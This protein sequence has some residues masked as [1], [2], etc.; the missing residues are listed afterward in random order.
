M[1]DLHNAAHSMQA[2]A[3]ERGAAEGAARLR[4]AVPEEHAHLAVQL[5]LAAQALPGLLLRQRRAGLVA[6]RLRTR[7]GLQRRAAGHAAAA[8]PTHTWRHDATGARAVVGRRGVPWRRRG[9]QRRG[10]REQPTR[11]SR[12]GL[13]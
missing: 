7:A 5:Q 4:V 2:H 13:G 6:E 12:V 11:G 8:R 9:L 3:C 1:R 10:W